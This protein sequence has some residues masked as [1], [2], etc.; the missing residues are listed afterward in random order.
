MADNIRLN[1]G[2]NGDTVRAKEVDGVKYQA[3]HVFNEFSHEPLRTINTF[4]SE[5]GAGTTI[6]MLGDYSGGGVGP[7]VFS[8]KPENNEFHVYTRVS[9]LM[10]SSGNNDELFLAHPVY[11]GKNSGSLLPNGI[12]LSY[13][14]LSDDMV[15][16]TSQNVV[17]KNRDWEILLGGV[18]TGITEDAGA[19]HY[20]RTVGTI[21]NVV[22]GGP[23]SEGGLY[24]SLNLS[25]DLSNKGLLE[26]RVLLTGVRVDADTYHRHYVR[27]SD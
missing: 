10:I 25:D 12:T 5:D 4:F 23:A 21:N 6:D 26:H 14:Q 7:K 9:V 1:A 11:G 22:V 16:A 8:L 17:T 2:I 18:T 19:F 15:V 3:V 24:L 20:L 13:R 27:L